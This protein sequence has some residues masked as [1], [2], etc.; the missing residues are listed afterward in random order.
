MFRMMSTTDQLPDLDTRPD[1]PRRP[2]YLL[3][4]MIGLFLLALIIAFLT[5]VPALLR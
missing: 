5:D 1:P 4:L 3:I 2:D